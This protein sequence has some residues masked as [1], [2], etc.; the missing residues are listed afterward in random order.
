MRQAQQN[1]EWGSK[2]KG[3]SPALEA[4][5]PHA[6]PRGGSAVSLAFVPW[7]LTPPFFIC[8]TGVMMPVPFTVILVSQKQT[9]L[10][11]VPEESQQ[12]NQEHEW[13]S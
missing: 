11:E 12:I 3:Q 6:P 7:P 2:D 10:T 5:G 9:K 4:P 13:S 8:E 1:Q